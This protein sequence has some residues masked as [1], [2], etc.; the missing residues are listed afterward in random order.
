MPVINDSEITEEYRDGVRYYCSDKWTGGYPSVTSILGKTKSKRTMD[1]INRARCRDPIGFAE[2][3]KFARIRGTMGHW[4]ISDVLSPPQP[5]PTG[6]S[7]SDWPPDLGEMISSLGSIEFWDQDMPIEF[8]YPRLI[9][10][11]MVN[12]QHGFAGRRDLRSELSGIIQD[13]LTQEY[14][15]LDGS[16]IV[17]YKFS[18]FNPTWIESINDYKIQLAAYYMCDENVSDLNGAIN[19]Y[20]NFN[21]GVLNK[22]DFIHIDINELYEYSELFIKRKKIFD[23]LLK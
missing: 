16:Y 1:N 8:G 5:L 20:I 12:H 11:V 18:S 3:G 17:D 6:I 7:I 21:N 4:K 2:R 10:S 23:R 13:G 19:I 22:I 9:E 14:I 15:E